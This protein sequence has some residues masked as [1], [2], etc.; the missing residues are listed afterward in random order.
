MAKRLKVTR[1]D[2][3]AHTLTIREHMAMHLLSGLLGDSN[4]GGRSDCVK[5]AVE[6]TDSLIAK[7]NEGRVP[8]QET[9][10]S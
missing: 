3:S 1:P 9:K 5:Y 2:R 4:W 6:I 10:T 7:L 8:P